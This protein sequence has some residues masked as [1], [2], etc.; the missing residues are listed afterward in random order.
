MDRTSKTIVKT[1]TMKRTN[2]IALLAL[3][4]GSLGW[5]QKGKKAQ[6]IQS[7][8]GM[9]GCFKVTFKYTETFAPEID[10]E[11]HLDYN[12][13]ALELAL[14]IEESPNKIVLQHLLVINDTMVIKHWRQDWEYENQKIFSYDKDNNWVFKTLPK[15][16]VKGQWSQ[17]VYQTEDSPRYSGSG[18]WFHADGRNFWEDRVDA[19]LPRRE[20]SKRHDY[21]VMHRGNT[22]EI[23]ADGWVHEQDN[24]KI[25]REDGQPDVL[26][27]QEKGYNTYE[28][29]PDADCAVAQKW[30]AEHGAF[31]G[32]V[33][34]AWETI[35]DREGNLTLKKEVD[36]KPLFMYMDAIEANGGGEKEIAETLAKFVET[37]NA[38]ANGK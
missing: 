19:P 22:H 31:W 17:L 35:Y 21:N 34:K 20:Y 37:P 13:Y 32:K 3:L 2:Y 16:Q 25:V 14:P 1:N 6:D 7:I 38:A 26:L 11:K 24:E 10:Y 23:T 5:A 9:C 18:T 33:R 4:V 36:G 27:V 28:R 15:D 30:W 8:K 29:R 12:A